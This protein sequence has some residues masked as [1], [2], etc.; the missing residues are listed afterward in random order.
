MSQSATRMQRQTYSHTLPAIGIIWALLAAGHASM[1]CM[2]KADL[3]LH[4]YGCF[5]GQNGTYLA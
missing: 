1:F 5:R 4:T 2:P 3:L